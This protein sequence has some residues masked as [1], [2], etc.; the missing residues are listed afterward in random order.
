MRRRAYIRI[1][2]AATVLTLVATTL[3]PDVILPAF[4]PWQSARAAATVKLIFNAIAGP[5]QA[6][7]GAFGVWITSHGAQVWPA[8]WPAFSA[9]SLRLGA[10]AIPFWFAVGA[11]AFEV[12]RA[13]TRLARRRNR[14][15]GGGSS[16]AV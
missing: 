11:V 8:G 2:V 15:T 5:P 1:F 7:A 9:L 16:S 4:N 6:V 12:T 14:S 3:A 10:I 13:A